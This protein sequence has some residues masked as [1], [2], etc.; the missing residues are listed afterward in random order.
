MNPFLTPQQ[1]DRLVL[2]SRSPRRIEIMRGLGFDFEIEPAPEHLEDD[3]DHH[4]PFEIAEMLAVRKCEY[5]AER[6]PNARVIAADTIVVVDGDVLNKPRDDAEARA[7]VR[8]LAGSTHTV[9][10][11]VAIRDGGRTRAGAERTQVTFR[12]LTPEQI[13][14]YVATGEGRDKAGSYAAQGLGAGLIRRIE[15]CFFNVVGLP[16]G[17]VLDLLQ[18]E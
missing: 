9:V 2:A 3:D 13:A 16:V 5:V 17:L 1:Q 15:G 10:T 18:R 14:N 8:R 11:G 6:R 4:D 7:F 12:A